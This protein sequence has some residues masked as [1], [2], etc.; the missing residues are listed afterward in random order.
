MRPPTRSVYGR[1]ALAAI[2]AG[3]VPLALATVGTAWVVREHQ[4]AALVDRAIHRG[5]AAREAIAHRLALGRAELR[6]VA[7]AADAGRILEAP[8]M[9]SDSVL[10][11][12]C[13]REGDVL[14]DAATSPDARRRLE[15]ARRSEAGGLELIGRDQI[16]VTVRIGAI[17]ASA[18]HDLSSIV[19]GSRRESL[20]LEL[21]APPPTDEPALIARRFE[22]AEG[23]EGVRVRVPVGDGLTVTS[24]TSLAPARRAAFETI[25]RVLWFSSLGVV[26]LLLL[27]WLGA[28][29]VTRPIRSLAAAVRGARG[30]RLELPPLSRDEIGDLGGA[31]AA[32]SGRLHE[33]AQSLHAAVTF[34]R[35]LNGLSDGEAV[36]EALRLALQGTVPQVRWEVLSAAQIAEGI[37]PGEAGTSTELL[38]RV[39]AGSRPSSALAEDDTQPFLVHRPSSKGPAGEDVVLLG[40]CD[41]SRDYAVVAGVGAALD[42]EC[43]RHAEL[44]ARTAVGA[45]RNKD[46]VRAAL[47]NERLLA[48]GRLA[49]GV[50]HEMNNPLAFVLANLRTLESRLGGDDRETAVEAR[51]GTERLVRIVRDLSSLSRGGSALE[52]AEVDLAELA[53]FVAR[54]TAGRRAEVKIVI[55]APERVIAS[56]DRGRLEQAL[57]NLVVNAVDATK[58]RPEPLVRIR[59]YRDADRCVV[60]VVDNGGGVPP[61]ARAQL[62]SPFF[63]TKGAEG[64]GLGLYLSRS[65]AQAHGGDLVL[66]RTSSEGTAFQL[67]VPAGPASAPRAPSRPAPTPAAGS[68]PPRVLVVDDEEVLLRSMKRWI[69]G[70]A[71]VTITSDPV[72]ALDLAAGG[73]FA[74]VLC[75]LHMPRMSGIEFVDALRIR[76]ESAASRVVIMTGSGAATVAPPFRAVDKPLQPTVLEELLAEG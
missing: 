34:A 75:D 14:L 9:V 42:E 76:D 65:F 26:P 68:A 29:A 36:L 55:D 73:G 11:V 57:L 1:V 64:T 30:N 52:M 3:I 58:G 17:H 38:R 47:T 66:E 53:R 51:E 46:L 49:A 28:R 62:F 37:L 63:T 6:A 2:V 12:R 25:R 19:T 41:A 56:G 8:S 7:L 60:E 33:N 13:A 44:L 31:I 70:R 39:L 22:D 61:A 10:A 40:L 69:G 54:V 35:R 4:E 43:V 5:E 50:A 15:R 72:E 16:V 67:L 48:A 20:V 27:A 71:D 32:M 23:R 21:G 45:L 74:L 59:V 18:L 24:T